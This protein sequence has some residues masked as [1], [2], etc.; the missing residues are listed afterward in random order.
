MYTDTK[1]CPKLWNNLKGLAKNRSCNI[2][3][4]KIPWINMSGNIPEITGYFSSMLLI[5][6]LPKEVHS[7][8]CTVVKW[9]GIPHPEKKRKGCEVKLLFPLV[10]TDPTVLDQNNV[11]FFGQ[12]FSITAILKGYRYSLWKHKREENGT[13]EENHSSWE[14]L[15]L[16]EVFAKNTM[17]I[18]PLKK[19]VHM[20]SQ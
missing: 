3:W 7:Y 19:E 12:K 17:Q 16:S 10:S 9:Q 11:D 8:A 14:A 15:L 6:L 1:T 18:Y 2:S 5:I 20:L 4:T 13:G